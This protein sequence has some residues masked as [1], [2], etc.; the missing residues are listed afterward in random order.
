MRK[1]KPYKGGRTFRPSI[2]LTPGE[3]KL[4]KSKAAEKGMSVS[5][6]MVDRAKKQRKA[7]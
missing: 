2:R 3:W 7:T 1:I 6:W 4:I 5:D